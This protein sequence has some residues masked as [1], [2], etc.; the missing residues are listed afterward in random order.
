MTVYLREFQNKISKTPYT[1]YFEYNTFMKR[2]FDILVYRLKG[3]HSRERD[4]EREGGG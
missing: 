2:H 1:K 4:R 3:Y